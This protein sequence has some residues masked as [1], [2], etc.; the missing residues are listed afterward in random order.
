MSLLLSFIRIQIRIWTAPA[1]AMSEIT[2]MIL[3]CQM[4]QL[5]ETT[6][7]SDFE[8]FNFSFN[9]RG[10][11][12][13]VCGGV[14]LTSEISEAK[15]SWSCAS[16]AKEQRSTL[17]EAEEKRLKLDSRVKMTES[18]LVSPPLRLHDLRS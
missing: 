3:C 15:E 13:K 7:N 2:V 14:L 16:E 8:N 10:K 11:K 17:A 9:G 4:L 12:R 6:R 5:D 1:F 18:G